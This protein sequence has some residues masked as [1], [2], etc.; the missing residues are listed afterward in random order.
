LAGPLAPNDALRDPERVELVGEG[1]LWRPEDITFDDQ[2]RLY[3]PS[4]DRAGDGAGGGDLNARIERVTFGP[5]GRQTVE[6]FVRLPGG[7]PLDLRFDR[8]GN[9]IVASWGQG[10]LSISPDRRVT[11]LVADGQPI[12]G[13]PFGYADGVAIAGDGKIY[14][15]QGQDARGARLGAVLMTLEQRAYG[16]LLVYD[17]ANG[18][19]RT[20]TPDL[21]FGNGIALAP[22]ESYVLVADQLRCQIKRY[23]LTGPR[24]GTEDIFADNLPGFVHNLSLDDR[25]VLWM[26]LAQPRSTLADSIAGSPFLRRQVAKL[27]PLLAGLDARTA[28]GDERRRGV[29]IVMA[30]DLA[31]NP[32]LGLHN[33]PMSMNTLSAA[34]Y[35]DGYVYIGTIG[36]GPVL[37]YRLPDR[38][39]PR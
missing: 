11:T 8:A 29:G 10:L 23:W 4:R 2:G 25:G 31:G 9:L 26:A 19:V 39:L 28:G 6:E 7:G 1:R 37:R 18:S 15:T 33:P 16:R 35:H 13:R 20:L 17:P 38:P 24:A 27:A 21:S 30:M 14:F 5:D 32:L 3:A 34:V 22:D 12:D 36:G